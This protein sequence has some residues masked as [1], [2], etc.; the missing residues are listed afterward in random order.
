MRLF[1]QHPLSFDVAPLLRQIDAAPELWNAHPWR[2]AGETSPHREAPDI[3]VRFRALGELTRPNHGNEQ[4]IS[5]WYPA[6][7]K[8]S[9]VRPIARRLMHHLHGVTLGGILITKVPPRKRVY[10]HHD[11]GRWHAEYFNSKTYVVLR[12]NPACVNRA[13]SDPTSPL[14]EDVYMRAGEAWG[15]DNQVAHEVVN[16]GPTDRISLIVCARVE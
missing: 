12:S 3:W 15:F 1:R 6:I 10:A 7:E 5:T 13:W 14:P 11:R 2:T 8:L 9:E 4:H 16:D